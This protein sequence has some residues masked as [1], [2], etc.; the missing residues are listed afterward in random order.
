ML[1]DAVCSTS[2]TVSNPRNFDLLLPLA[3]TCRVIPLS[4]GSFRFGTLSFGRALPGELRT[5]P[6]Y[7]A[8]QLPSGK[9]TEL[10]AN[11][12]PLKV[13]FGREKAMREATELAGWEARTR[14]LA[15]PL[16][17][18]GPQPVPQRLRT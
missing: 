14:P 5:L 15:E 2:S 13:L 6:V 18:R 17:P 16:S 12:M 4:T 7:D 10:A 11:V 8:R 1:A 3:F 9:D